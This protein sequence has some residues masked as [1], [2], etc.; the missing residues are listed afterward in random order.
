MSNGSEGN[1]GYTLTA[2]I[3]HWLTAALA[4]SGFLLGLYMVTLKFSPIKLRYFSY[5]KW[6]GVTILLLGIMRLIWRFYH[7]APKM[8]SRMPEWEKAF[9]RGAHA[10]L[11]CLIFLVPITGWLMS[12]AHG[13]QTV[14]FG[15]LPLPNILGKDKDMAKL[16]EGVHFG[17]NKA[18]IIAAFLHAAAAVKHHVIDKDDILKRM[19]GY[20]RIRR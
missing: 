2:I 20:G 1:G 10:F 11:Y 5:H 13:L 19:L 4:A 8:P 7:P 6:I 18:L 14:Y 3:L 12:S 17:F 16:L 15:V 9:A